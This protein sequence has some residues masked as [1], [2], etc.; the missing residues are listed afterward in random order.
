MS[1]SGVPCYHQP[2]M[3]LLYPLTSIFTLLPTLSGQSNYIIS[4]SCV[5]PDNNEQG[6]VSQDFHHNF[7][8][9]QAK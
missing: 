1:W 9:W 4:K 6:T 8:Q 2:T 7:P 3:Y 5:T